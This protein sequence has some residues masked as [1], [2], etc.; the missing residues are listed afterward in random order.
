MN[1]REFLASVGVAAAAVAVNGIPLSEVPIALND[2]IFHVSDVFTIAG[3]Y[4]FNPV[5]MKETQHLQHFI[6]TAVLQDSVKFMPYHPDFP[7]GVIPNVL[8]GPSIG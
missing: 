4:A 1:R 7:N 5:T 3:K 6:V 2:E 8:V